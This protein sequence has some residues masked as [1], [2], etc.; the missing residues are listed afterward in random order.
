MEIAGL[1]RAPDPTL[2]RHV[3]DLH[4]TRERYDIPSVVALEI[5]S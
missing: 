3:Y 5:M 1:S 4:I 2:V